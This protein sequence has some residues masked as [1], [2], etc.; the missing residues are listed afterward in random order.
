MTT[1][2][3]IPYEHELVVDREYQTRLA[4]A[5]GMRVYRTPRLYLLALGFLLLGVGVMSF[6]P[7]P[8][9]VGA[10]FMVVILLILVPPL[11]NVPLIRRRIE[12][13]AP[14][15]SVYESGFGETEFVTRGPEGSTRRPYTSFVRLRIDGRF[16]V[17]RSRAAKVDIFCPAELFP[18]EARDRFIAAG[19][20]LS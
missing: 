10:A 20:R 18:A 11:L 16:V 5:L 13:S 15:G 3:P 9:V 8:L 14:V 4:R 1:D 17:L 2:V 12:R 19:V 6:S 7:T